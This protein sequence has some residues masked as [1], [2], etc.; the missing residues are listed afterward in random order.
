MTTLT[1]QYR[2]KIT[3][4]LDA[5][6]ADTDGCMELAI[7][8][9]TEALVNDS[10][11]Y[12][13]GSGHSHM[14]AEE[15]FYR[16]GGIAAAQAILEPELML[17]LGARRST[18][19]ERKEG[20][21]AQVLA[22]YAIKS[23]DIVFVVSNSGRNAF[24]I[25]CALVAKSHGAKVVALTSLITSS[26]ITSRHS[27]GQLLKDI[28]DI[29]LDNQAPV[30]DATLAV[31]ALGVTMA[32]ASTITGTFTLNAILAESVSRATKRGAKVDVYQS[33]NAPGQDHSAEQMAERWQKRVVGL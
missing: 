32:P 7:S 18:A 8:M 26:A 28:A 15:V 17:H 12:V 9:V 29:V 10:M 3:T 1:Q 25:E 19:A 33:A 30:G 27:S 22:R 2:D 11:I 31:P 6:V 14:V 24:P 21:A 4:M 16:A 5:I 23:G 13:V 20:T